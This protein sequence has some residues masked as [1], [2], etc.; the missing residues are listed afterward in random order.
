[1][2]KNTTADLLKDLTELTTHLKD[3]YK[4]DFACQEW[5][6]TFSSKYYKKLVDTCKPTKRQTRSTLKEKLKE[7]I[8]KSFGQ[9]EVLENFNV[10]ISSEDKCIESIR[11]L[12]KQIYRNKRNIVY[13]THQ[14][15]FII[16]NLR[17]V[18]PKDCDLG[19]YFHLRGVHYTDSYCRNLALVYELIEKHKNLLKCALNTGTLIK[20]RKL[21]EEICTELNW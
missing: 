4:E 10:D 14:I 20:N 17:S 7:E 6:T 18:C 21:I 12:D 13:C 19:L 16:K 9:E 11:N 1:M 8:T 3:N 15:G 5:A 2:D